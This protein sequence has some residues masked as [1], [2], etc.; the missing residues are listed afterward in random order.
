MKMQGLAF[1]VFVATSLAL[2]GCTAVPITSEAGNGAVAAGVKYELIGAYDIDRLN[3]IV[4]TEL[5]E[6][7]TFKTTYPP[8]TV[9][10]K[11]YRITYPSVIPEQNNRPTIASGLVAIP[12]TGAATMPVV[13]YQHGTVFSKTEVP[14]NPEESMETRLMIAQFA[15]QGYIVVAADYFGKGISPETDSYTVKASTQQACLDM[16]FAAQAVTAD[17]DIQMGP[18][19]VS[20]W[21]Q[22]GWSTMV[23]L[24]KLESL[25][26]PVKAAAIASAPVDLF[27]TTNRWMQAPAAI[28]A[29]YLP[30]VLLLQLYAYEEYYGL[31]G[32]AQSAIKPEYQET[33]HALYLNKLTYAEAAPK[34]PTTI[35]ELLQS[36]FLAASSIGDTRYYRLVQDN[37][38]YR[39]RAST[40]VHTY[41]GDI[42]EVVPPYIATLPVGYQKIMG[43]APVTAVAS[44][45]EADHRGNFVFAVADQKKWFDEVLGR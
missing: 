4:T 13:S 11:L 30:G 33:A 41:Y 26:I 44:G 36:D 3:Q 2:N 45:S 17:L 42:D 40:P 23:F 5:A 25:G 19:F 8:A 12:E 7:S 32:L 27:A 28:D 20:G 1:F 31:P 38:A 16:L 34:L 22:G 37:H 43:G 14:S 35:N 24:N 29:V 9:A 15:G 21:S 39:W 6:F 18:L 10:V